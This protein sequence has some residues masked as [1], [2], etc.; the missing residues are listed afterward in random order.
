VPGLYEGKVEY[1]AERAEGRWRIKEFDLPIHRWRFVWTEAGR[2]KWFTMF[3][4]IGEQLG[5]PTSPKW[6]GHPVSGKITL[7][8]NPLSQGMIQFFHTV[9]VQFPGLGFVRNGTFSTELPA[10]SYHVVIHHS[11]PEVPEKY[12]TPGRS[13]LM[14]EVKEG[15]NTFDFELTSK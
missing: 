7:D 15:E 14:I 3:G 10:G 4:D 2:W 11:K 13:G 5:N 1:V 12:R 6:P 8:G 9:D